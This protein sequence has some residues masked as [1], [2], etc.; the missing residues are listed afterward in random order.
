[1]IARRVSAHLKPNMAAEF[2]RKLESEVIPLLRK[3]AG[4]QDEITLTTEDGTKAIGLSFWD[5]KE[6]A[7]AYEKGAYLQVLT[8]LEKLV[9]GT[10]RVA[11]Y[12]VVNSTCHRLIAPAMAGGA[13]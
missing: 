6:S 11:T 7:E 13:R 1:M 10:P 5:R 8:M 4:F 12:E 2:T 9:E 3:Q